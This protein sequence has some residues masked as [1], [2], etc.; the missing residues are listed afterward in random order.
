MKRVARATSTTARWLFLGSLLALGAVCGVCVPATAVHAQR[1]EQPVFTRADTL[2]GSNGPARAWWDVTF[3]DLSVSI[4]PASRSISGM[5]RIHY[6]VLEA[7]PTG[8]MQIDLQAPLVLDS[9]VHR[10]RRV[11]VRSE[12]NAHFAEVGGNTEGGAMAGHVEVGAAGRHAGIGAVDSV[13][14]H[15]HGRPVV[16]ANPPWDGGFIWTEDP[17]GEPWVATANQG[18]GASVWW[19]NKDYQG[20]EPD[21]QR[22][23]LT[24]PE[25][26]TAVSNGRL[27]EVTRNDDGTATWSWF[28]ASPINNYAIA[29]NVGTFAH[30]R[31]IH[32]GA[33]GPLTLDFWP[34]ADNHAAAR[35]QW[36]QTRP[37][38]R[39]FE[40]WFGPYPWYEDG[41]KM[42]ESP[43]LGMEHQSAI[44]YGNGY[45][46]G[47]LGRDLSG[48]GQ[49]LAWDFIIVHEAAHEWWGNNLTTEDVADMWVHEGFANYAE[50]LYTECLAGSAAAGA[51]YVIGTRDAIRNDVPIIGSYGVQ[52]QGSGDMYYK[53]GN[54][55]HTIRQLVGD[56]ARWR[57]ILRGLQRDFRRSIVTSAQ[58][59]DYIAEASGLRLGPVFDQYLRTTMVPLLEWRLE[60]TD[61]SYRWADVVDGF[62]MPVDVTTSEGVTASKGAVLRLRPTREWRTT[63]VAPGTTGITVDADFYVRSRKVGS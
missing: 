62:A 52:H 12:G 50:N 38:L 35:V 41:F 24:L 34:I 47:Y 55:L 11:P 20:E 45:Q 25:A 29:V 61:L 57:S 58:V 43:H 42:I 48:T 6:R 1:P 40:E 5:N 9:V 4:D 3:Y 36:T 7:P 28:V 18:L 60:G 63:V 31:E 39:C 30:W 19:P 56:D 37:M 27:R 17:S 13:A 26:M 46:N 21:S 51:E 14:V 53:G 59:E 32:D 33:E 54:L 15:Y 49:G 16:A 22:V 8:E 2:R 10:G 44:A 23:A